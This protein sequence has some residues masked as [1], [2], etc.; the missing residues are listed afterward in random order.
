MKK[1]YL[2]I[3]ALAGVLV[4]VG[5]GCY[6]AGSSQVSS[7]TTTSSRLFSMPFSLGGAGVLLAIVKWFMN[8]VVLVIATVFKL[9]IA[10]ILLM[11][12]GVGITGLI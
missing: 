10:F 5:I 2:L 9:I 7:A 8:K 11:A 1:N 4:V 3:I 12:I 6:W